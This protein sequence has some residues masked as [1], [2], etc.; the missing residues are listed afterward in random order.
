MA[1]PAA[2]RQ[3]LDA[4][5][6][7]RGRTRCRS[8]MP[9][10]LL[11][12]ERRLFYVAVTRARERLVHDRD[13]G[14]RRPR[15]T[16]VAIARRDRP[17]AARSG[18]RDRRT[19]CRRHRW[20]RGCG[21]RCAIPTSTTEL[22]ARLPRLSRRPRRRGRRRRR[23]A[24]AGRVAGPL[25]GA[26]GGDGRRRSRC[27]T[28]TGR[29]SCPA[30]RSRRSTGARARGSSTARRRR[31]SRR[32]PRKDSG[33]SC[34]PSPRRSSSASC[35]PSSTRSSNAS[36]RSGICC[37]TTRGGKRCATHDEA[38]RGAAS[39]SWPGTRPT[40]ASASSAEVKFEVAVGDDIVMRGRADR[41]ELDADGGLVVVDLKTEQHSPPRTSG[42]RPMRSS[43]S[44]SSS[45]R[46]GAFKRLVDDARRRRA[47]AAAQGGA[48]AR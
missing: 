34:T 43:A 16:P 26:A 21:A 41:I 20:S 12:D 33:R 2:A 25:V 15:G 19:C 7:R 28:P 38:T 44:T 6:P 10:A 42:S 40:T 23:A 32:R 29:S 14:H 1:G 24:G 9:A 11:T 39:G 5:A 37:P 8:P 3:L 4:D 18:D 48:A 30:R 47:R 13:V 31:P 45:M 22:R 27:A 35:P 36:T 46:Q 17:R